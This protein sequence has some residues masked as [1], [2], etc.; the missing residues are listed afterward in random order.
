MS[1]KGFTILMIS[2]VVLVLGVLWMAYID[3][4]TKKQNQEEVIEITGEPFKIKRT[5][6]RKPQKPYWVM[7]ME[8]QHKIDYYID[9][10]NNVTTIEVWEKGG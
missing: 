10:D 5:T 6:K 4:E 2:M 3:A 9:R 7:R 8:G 1:T